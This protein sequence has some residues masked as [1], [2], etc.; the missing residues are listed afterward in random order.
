[1]IEAASVETAIAAVVASTEIEADGPAVDLIAIV[2]D[3]LAKAD[4]ATEGVEIVDPEKVPL[5]LPEA[6]VG[7]GERE[8]DMDRGHRGDLEAT[9]ATA[10]HAKAATRTN[11]TVNSQKGGQQSGL[12]FVL[13]ICLFLLRATRGKVRR[14]SGLFAPS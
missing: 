10:P 7:L 8:V 3:L 6:Q 4:T 5:A 2:G 9:T 1:M 14:A 11:F 12:P 13:V